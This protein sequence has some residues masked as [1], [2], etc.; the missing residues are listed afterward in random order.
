MKPAKQKQA[1]EGIL[2]AQD[3]EIVCSEFAAKLPRFV[4]LEIAG[5]NAAKQMPEVRQHIHQCPECG[6]V[7]RALRE[8]VGKSS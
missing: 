7:Y 1:L 3:E 5:E 8:V 4:D 6:D 2:N